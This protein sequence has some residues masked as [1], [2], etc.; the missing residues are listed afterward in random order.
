MRFFLP[1]LQLVVYQAAHSVEYSQDFFEKLHLRNHQAA[2]NNKGQRLDPTAGCFP[3]TV[4][5]RLAYELRHRVMAPLDVSRVSPSVELTAVTYFIPGGLL[6]R[7]QFMER[8]SV[9]L[10]WFQEKVGVGG[11]RLPL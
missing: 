7:K 3:Q 5:R 2:R 11:F 1:V 10:F 4:P 9:F 8:W 6:N